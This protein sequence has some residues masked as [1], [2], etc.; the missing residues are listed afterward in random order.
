[1]IPKRG[2]RF[3]EKHA[4][5][6]DPKGSCSDNNVERDGDSKKSHLALK[7]TGAP[8]ASV[9]GGTCGRIDGLQD[10]STHMAPSRNEG[11]E[12]AGMSPHDEE[13]NIVRGR[14]DRDPAVGIALEP[15]R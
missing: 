14:N 1:M 8:G 11:R 6:L 15:L 9:V 13:M 10:G 5:G 7:R 4:L 3:S 12:P 2:H